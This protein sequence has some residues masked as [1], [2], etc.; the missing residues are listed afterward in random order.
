MADATDRHEGG[1]GSKSGLNS[2]TW[3]MHEPLGNRIVFWLL[4]YGSLDCFMFWGGEFQK[5]LEKLRNSMRG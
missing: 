4:D 5:D 2:V 1:E 3:F